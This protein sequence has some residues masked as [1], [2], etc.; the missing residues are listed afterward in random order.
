MYSFRVWCTSR[1]GL[2]REHQHAP[3]LSQFSTSAT[4]TSQVRVVH[5]NKE[6]PFPVTIQNAAKLLPK[7]LLSKKC[8]KRNRYPK[9]TFLWTSH[10]RCSVAPS[11]RAVSLV[12]SSK[13]A[14]PCPEP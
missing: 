3:L 7:M 12:V 13:P 4:L 11:T 5:L 2:C 1:V 8:F 10:N 9:L 6:L 14:L